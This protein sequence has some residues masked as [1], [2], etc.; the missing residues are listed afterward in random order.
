MAD[1]TY[2]WLAPDGAAFDVAG[3]NNDL[4]SVTPGSSLFETTNG[5]LNAANL[6]SGFNVRERMIQPWQ[7]GQAEGTGAVT[8]LDYFQDGGARWMAIPGA[9]V[10][11]YVRA[12]AGLCWLYGNLFMCHW[13]ARGPNTDTDPPTWALPPEIV[14]RLVLDGV[15]VPGTE[16]SLPEDIFFSTTK[17]YGD[18]YDFSFADEERATRNFNLHAQLPELA[19]GEHVL[20]WQVKVH[21]N[22]GS[23]DLNLD[24]AGRIVARGIFQSSNRVRVYTRGAHLVTLV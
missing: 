11:R 6:V 23:E 10:R 4:Y 19:R 12:T 3:Y 18:G 22:Q 17:V 8:P 13:R 15:Y 2:L 16:R 7:A 14:V 5:N 21:V 24:G 1:I 20:E 9:T